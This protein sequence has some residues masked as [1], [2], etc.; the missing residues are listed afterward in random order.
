MEYKEN[1]KNGKACLLGMVCLVFV[2]ENS[3]LFLKT[4]RTKKKTRRTH[5]DPSFF[6]LI[7]KENTKKSIYSK[8][9]T[10]FKEDK[11]N[12]F[13]DIKNNFQK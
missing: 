5:L 10:F 3:C 2:F 7:N 9:K 6:F 1:K 13:Y 4:K 11:N 12:V 8:N